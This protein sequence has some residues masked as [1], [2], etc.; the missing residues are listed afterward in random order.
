MCCVCKVLSRSTEN[1]QF[2]AIL[3][4]NQYMFYIINYKL[5]NKLHNNLKE[6]F[7]MYCKRDKHAALEFSRHIILYTLQLVTTVYYRTAA[8]YRS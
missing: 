4:E 2:T 6:F 8:G 5:Y 3:P 7:F 1:N